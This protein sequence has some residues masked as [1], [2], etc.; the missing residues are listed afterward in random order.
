MVYGRY[1]AALFDRFAFT[2]NRNRYIRLATSSADGPT[3]PPPKAAAAAAEK[4]VGATALKTKGPSSAVAAATT[5]PAAS[6]PAA[7]KTGAR[8]VAAA[9][10]ERQ[11][12]GMAGDKGPRGVA[13]VKV[14][15]L[16]NGGACNMPACIDRNEAKGACSPLKACAR[17]VQE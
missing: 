2:P 15:P 3:P 6:R 10:E 1:D 17:Y 16:S 12:A 8:K 13:V 4:K 9:A 14:V 11:A 5:R 7:C